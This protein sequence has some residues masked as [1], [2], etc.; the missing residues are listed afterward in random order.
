[1]ISVRND[2]RFYSIRSGIL[3][4]TEANDAIN[5]AELS[6]L[7]KE[8]PDGLINL[9]MLSFMQNPKIIIDSYNT[10]CWIL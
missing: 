3:S 8:F 10:K 4:A 5:N 9:Q 6:R 1:M 2:A 7:R